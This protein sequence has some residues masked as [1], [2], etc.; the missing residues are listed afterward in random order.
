MNQSVNILLLIILSLSSH[1][2]HTQSQFESK[3]GVVQFLEGRWSVDAIYGGF[4]GQEFKLPSPDYF[5]SAILTVS[6]EPTGIDSLPLSFKKFMND[7]LTCQSL[8]E[9]KDLDAGDML[10]RWRILHLPPE[11][12]FNLDIDEIDP[13]YGFS[14]DSLTLTAF[15]TYG[16]SRL[17]T[18]TAPIIEILELNC[19]PNPTAGI[20]NIDFPERNQMYDL[21]IYD[22]YGRLVMSKQY[23]ESI[24]SAQEDISY[25]VSGVYHVELTS[26]ETSHRVK[27]VTRIVKLD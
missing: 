12:G 3:E 21:H 6:F 24:K 11:F 20:I 2:G 16:M 26:K 7:S 4:S 13:K 15:I 23:S 1:V 8:V 19:Y 18:N 25:F 27:Y 14:Q 22:S 10:S 17:L 9:I 5:N